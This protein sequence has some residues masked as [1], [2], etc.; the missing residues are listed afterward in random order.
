MRFVGARGVTGTRG[1]VKAMHCKELTTTIPSSRP[2]RDRARA[3]AVLPLV[4]SPPSLSLPSFFAPSLPLP[5]SRHLS[6]FPSF[7]LVLIREPR[8]Y[9]HTH[10]LVLLLARLISRGGRVRALASH[11]C[12]FQFVL[13]FEISS[14]PKEI[15]CPF[16]I[17]VSSRSPILLAR[18]RAPAKGNSEARGL[19]SY[20]IRYTILPFPVSRDP[21]S[22]LL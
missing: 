14:I 15:R 12:I 7:P 10:T 21:W 2:S 5:L 17:S 3:R 19:G 11:S 18:T 16:G 1:I 13:C 4:L 22:H 8:Q 9:D 20:D 6:S